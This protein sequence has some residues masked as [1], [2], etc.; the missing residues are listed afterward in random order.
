MSRGD[1]FASLFYLFIS[2]RNDNN[3]ELQ[4]L[5]FVYVETSFVNAWSVALGALGEGGKVPR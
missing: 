1:R 5:L 3:A 2:K 4:R